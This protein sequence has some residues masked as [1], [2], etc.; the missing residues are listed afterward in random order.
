MPDDRRI[1][2]TTPRPRKQPTPA[3]TRMLIDVA[4]T[5]AIPFHRLLA[6]WQAGRIRVDARRRRIT[7]VQEAYDWTVEQAASWLSSNTV[8]GGTRS[9]LLS[10]YD[11]FRTAYR[12]V[13][14]NLHPD[15]I[16]PNG[17]WLTLQ[18]VASLLED[19]HKQ[20]GASA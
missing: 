14:A 3:Q 19:H 15:K 4:V 10:S 5:F 13:A 2:S 1:M 11:A 8:D 20:R 16:G 6:A 7:E 17:A 9:H 12:K 18:R